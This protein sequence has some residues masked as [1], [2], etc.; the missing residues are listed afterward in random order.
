MIKM[1]RPHAGDLTFCATGTLLLQYPSLNTILTLMKTFQ[2]Q[3]K[4]FQRGLKI[5]LGYVA[6]VSA[7][8][9]RGLWEILTSLGYNSLPS[10][11]KD[12]SL[13]ELLTILVDFMWRRAEHDR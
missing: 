13:I 8:L 1:T 4:I 2:T 5:K 10:S 9:K 6:Y 11:S 3:R 12:E 7:S